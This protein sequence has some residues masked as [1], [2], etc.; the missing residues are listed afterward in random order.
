MLIKIQDNLVFEIDTSRQYDPSFFWFAGGPKAQNKEQK[1]TTQLRCY[2]KNSIRPLELTSPVH[3]V[4]DTT[5]KT[6][7]VF[8]NF[9]NY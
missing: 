7:L 9:N 3:L 4:L 5:I 1:Q 2:K 8:N 6:N